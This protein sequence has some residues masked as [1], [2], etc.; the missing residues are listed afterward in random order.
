MKKI[1]DCKEELRE[2]Q[3]KATPPRIAVLRYLESKKEPLDAKSIFN[4]LHKRNIDIDPATVFRI[5]NVF[6]DKGIAKQIQLNEGKFRYELNR[7]DGHHHLICEHCGRIEDM[8]DCSI[9]ELET[10]IQKRKQFLVK[11]HSLEF[12]GLCKQCQR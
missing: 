9:G 4:H 8:S 11:S 6:T 5:L 1:H 3:L 10:D 2:M 7:N 12:F